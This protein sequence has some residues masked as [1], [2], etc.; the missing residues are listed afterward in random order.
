MKKGNVEDL[1]R[2][3]FDKT[4]NDLANQY[5]RNTANKEARS[6]HQQSTNKSAT[7]KPVRPEHAYTQEEWERLWAG[8]GVN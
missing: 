4:I 7:S 3:K 5:D 6:Q 8:E 1:T 2:E